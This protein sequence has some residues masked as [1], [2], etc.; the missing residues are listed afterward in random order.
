MR[1]IRESTYVPFSSSE[2][3]MGHFDG[4]GSSF[5]HALYF[6]DFSALSL[7]LYFFSSVTGGGP[8]KSISR[9]PPVPDA[10]A[11]FNPHVAI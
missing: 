7:T 5:D 6:A 2:V 3:L 1:S 8:W 11:V 4:H 10:D 9:S